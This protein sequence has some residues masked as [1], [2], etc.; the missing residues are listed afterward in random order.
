MPKASQAGTQ[1]SIREFSGCGDQTFWNCRTQSINANVD[2]CLGP[3]LSL[4]RNDRSRDAGMTALTQLRY[5]S[6]SSY[7]TVAAIVSRI[8][9]SGSAPIPA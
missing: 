6:I 7:A 2:A 5:A 4:L 1:S 9:A 8:A 3:R